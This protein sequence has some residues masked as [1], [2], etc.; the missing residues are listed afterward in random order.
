MLNVN[1]LQNYKSIQITI[2]YVDRDILPG[3]KTLVEFIRHN[4]RDQVRV[5][6][7]SRLRGTYGKFSLFCCLQTASCL[8]FVD[9]SKLFF[10]IKLFCVKSISNCAIYRPILKPLLYFK[11]LRIKILVVM[12]I[13]TYI[14]PYIINRTL[15]GGKKI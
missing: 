11:Q 8:R 2:Y 15:H 6:R 7:L 14:S 5:F 3:T 10:S 4:I 1:D 12:Y 13:C 9:F